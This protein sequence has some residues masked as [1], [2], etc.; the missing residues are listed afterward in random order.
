MFLKT[1]G[2]LKKG[3]QTIRRTT[4]GGGG[5]G[6]GGARRGPAHVTHKGVRERLEEATAG[7]GL[8]L[9]AM[10]K[11]T[12][13]PGH[14]AEK[15]ASKTFCISLTV[16]TS[17]PDHLPSISASLTGA[18]PVP[19][20][21]HLPQTSPTPQYQQEAGVSNTIIHQRRTIRASHCIIMEMWTLTLYWINKAFTFM[22][23]VLA[24]R[25]QNNQIT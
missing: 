17:Y 7:L 14:R 13:A 4:R 5:G 21:L 24:K 3:K 1:S 9:E 12:H 20:R 19:R 23:G 25:D 6:A 11:R 10:N 8:E 15:R 2:R 16:C 18:V 22:M